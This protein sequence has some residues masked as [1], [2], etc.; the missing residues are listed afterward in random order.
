[1]NLW[2][3]LPAIAIADGD[4]LIAEPVRQ[5][6]GHCGIGIGHFPEQ[7]DHWWQISTPAEVPPIADEV[8][9]AIE[10]MPFRILQG[11]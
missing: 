9:L 7:K 6:F 8:R 10:N 5:R 1:M 3:Y 4:V 2:T 11:R